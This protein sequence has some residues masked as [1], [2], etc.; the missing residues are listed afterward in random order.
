MRKGLYDYDEDKFTPGG[1]EEF[2][3]NDFVVFYGTHLIATLVARGSKYIML[4]GENIVIDA[5]VGKYTSDEA[6]IK[7]LHGITLDDNYKSYLFRNIDD[8]NELETGRF[9]IKEMRKLINYKKD[10]HDNID[11]S[12][13]Y[14]SLRS[15]PAPARHLNTADLP[16]DWC[17]PTK[18]AA[19]IFQG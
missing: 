8:E 10:I 1:H 5:C 12:M 13:E 2:F 19:R 9:L 18:S 15:L 6:R 7:Y 3:H 16:S 11:P 14:K 4:I 17:H